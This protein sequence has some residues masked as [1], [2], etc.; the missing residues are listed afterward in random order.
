VAETF[1]Y[2]EQH[3][4]A[5]QLIIT[6][7]FSILWLKSISQQ[8]VGDIPLPRKRRRLKRLTLSGW[9]NLMREMEQMLKLLRNKQK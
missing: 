6:N 9:G 2:K 5:S 3:S 8:Y 7:K 1:A 4:A